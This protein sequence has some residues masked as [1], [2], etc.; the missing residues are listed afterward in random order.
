M[1]VG[2]RSRRSKRSRPRQDHPHACGDKTSTLT[3]LPAD[4]GSSPCVWG[5]VLYGVIQMPKP[6]IIPM[7]VGT[8]CCHSTAQSLPEDHPHACGDKQHLTARSSRRAGSSPCVWGQ[9][10]SA[11]TTLKNP[12][13]IPMRVGTR[14]IFIP[15]RITV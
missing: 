7:R 1:R 11:S 14:Y 9:D 13:I 5:Q 2:T 10:S 3:I 15:P 8:S 4:T 12:G 6:G